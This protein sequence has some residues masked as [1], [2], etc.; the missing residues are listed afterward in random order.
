MEENS[1]DNTVSEVTLLTFVV[2]MKNLLML[3][4]DPHGEYHKI[5]EDKNRDKHMRTLGFTVIRFEN[6]IV[7][8]EPEYLKSEIRKAFNNKI[9]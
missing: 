9:E 2:L 7:F 6:R 1:E 5:E 3:D 4:G 8:Q